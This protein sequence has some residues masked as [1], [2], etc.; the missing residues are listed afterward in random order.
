[1]ALAL[2]AALRAALA[3]GGGG[4]GGGAG[5]DGDPPPSKRARTEPPAEGPG[6]PGPSMPGGEGPEERQ[7]GPWEEDA[8][9]VLRVRLGEGG[10]WFR[11]EF[12]H[13]VFGADEIARG[14]R[15]L[16]VGV[17]LDPLSLHALVEISFE[18]EGPKGTPKDDIPGLLRE[19]LCL[20]FTEDVREFRARGE[21]FRESW[22]DQVLPQG[23]CV[24]S[25]AARG[26]GSLSL[27]RFRPSDSEAVRS[28]HDRMQ[29]FVLL[30]IDGG[31]CIDNREDR[32]DLLVAVLEL[33]GRASVA[34]FATLYSFQ[35]MVGQPRLRLSQVVVL[36]PFQR[37]GLGTALIE[38][39][40][41]TAGE[42]GASEATVEV[43]SPPLQAARERV[44]LKRLLQHPGGRFA[45]AAQEM[46][47]AAALRKGQPE[48]TEL[49]AGRQVATEAREAFGIPTM[50]FRKVWEGLLCAEI[51]ARRG[52][53]ARKE[54]AAAELALEVLVRERL[55]ARFSGKPTPHKQLHEL[56]GREFFLWRVRGEGAKSNIHIIME[57]EGDEGEEKK[58]EVV[59]G[60]VQERLEWLRSAAAGV[61]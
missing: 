59:E 15:G 37:R 18:A 56:Q 23:R 42:Q 41:A 35:Q 16:C 22:E 11:P 12:V 20:D 29:P 40:Y 60:L 28:W 21:R 48:S 39:F 36:P 6:G 2:A 8:E 50:H 13:Q 57:D 52:G 46:V 3:G 30:F 24:D 14:Y 31:S 54:L 26:G 27:H 19:K 61:S 32:W 43:P 33:E 55:R 45:E 44:D 10:E 49:E 34:G 1:M 53:M 5:G 51:E 7:L 17:T 4:G 47:K 9:G 38:A 58:E 25:R